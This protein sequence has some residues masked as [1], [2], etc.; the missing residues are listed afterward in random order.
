[1]LWKFPSRRRCGSPR[2]IQTS[3][4]SKVSTKVRL[5]ESQNVCRCKLFPCFSQIFQREIHLVK[6]CCVCSQEDQGH[7]ERSHM[8]KKKQKVFCS[9]WG[10]Q[11]TSSFSCMLIY[12]WGLC[13]WSFRLKIHTL[14]RALPRPIRTIMES[15]VKPAAFSGKLVHQ[16]E[17]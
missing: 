11:Q 15:F 5:C 10:P 12:C 8:R 3:N 14:R 7:V 4:T 2:R 9:F 13:F 16:A 17:Y 1:M 6:T